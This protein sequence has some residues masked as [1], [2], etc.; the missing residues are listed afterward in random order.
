MNFYYNGKLVKTS[1]TR[2]YTHGVY[3]S[4]TDSVWS[5]HLTHN[6]AVKAKTAFVSK[7]RN[8]YK[9]DEDTARQIEG[10]LSIVVLVEN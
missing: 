6:A 8:Y 4:A 10:E 9:V 5:C 2:H 3:S 1:K 7:A